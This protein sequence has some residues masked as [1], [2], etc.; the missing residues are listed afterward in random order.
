[1]SEG[2]AESGDAPFGVMAPDAASPPLAPGDPAPWFQARSDANPNFKFSSLGGRYIVL[3]FL[4]SFSKSEAAPVFRDFLEGAGRF[5]AFTTAL[6][7]VTADAGDEGAAVPTSLSGVRYF[8]DND[9]RIEALFDAPRENAESA[10]RPTTYIIDERLRI[11]AIVST[12]DAANHAAQVYAL[13]DRLPPLAPIKSS[14]RQAPVL[15]VPRVFEPGLCEALIAGYQ[16]H[17]GEDSGFMVERDGLTVATFD[18]GHK[19]RSDWNMEDAALIKACHTRIQRRLVPEIARAFQFNASRIERNTVACY[20]AETGGHFNRHRDNTTKGTAHR[21]FAVSIN[22]NAEGHEGGDLMFPEFGG[23]RFRP[24]TG[25]A[26]VFSCSLLHEAT[27]VT[28]GTRYVFVPFLYDDAA[29]E[30]R[31]QNVRFLGGEGGKP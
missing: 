18:Y 6:I 4:G 14:E 11:L 3:T 19:R 16:A 20:E 1:M 2:L 13:F 27:I 12:R 15:I 30:L 26:C 9:R 24:P 8:F 25:G 21:R 7:L 17:G 29:A 22:L 28:K 23:A 31:K 5:G 10:Y